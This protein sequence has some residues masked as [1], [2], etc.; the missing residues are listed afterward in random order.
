MNG[1]YSKVFETEPRHDE[2]NVFVCSTPHPSATELPSIK[3]FLSY[4]AI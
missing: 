1:S 4:S 2:E 3:N